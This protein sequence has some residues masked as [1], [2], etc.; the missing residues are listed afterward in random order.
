MKKDTFYSS[1]SC[2]LLQQYL[3]STLQAQDWIIIREAVV[4]RP[5]PPLFV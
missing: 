2:R 4:C 5:N 3:Q 1:Y